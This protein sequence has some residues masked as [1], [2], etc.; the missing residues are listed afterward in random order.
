M[1]IALGLWSVILDVVQSPRTGKQL[2]KCLHNKAE[3]IVLSTTLS[4][5]RTILI[6]Q[7]KIA[8][9]LLQGRFAH[10]ASIALLLFFGEVINGHVFFVFFSLRTCLDSSHWL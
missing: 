4:N 10:V 2:Q 8:S 6:I 5:E 1:C 9:E 3:T 7:M